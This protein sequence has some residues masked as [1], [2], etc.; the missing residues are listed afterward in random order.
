MMPDLLRRRREQLGLS[1]GELASKLQD[2]GLE[3]TRATVS[4]WETGRHPSPFDSVSAIS[5]L[6]EILGISLTDLFKTATYELAAEGLSEA[7]RAAALTVDR[8]TPEG[9]QIALQQLK[10]LEVYLAK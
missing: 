2:A 7:A 4:H 1:Q 8:L 3:I 5:A 9:Q 6:A 10:A